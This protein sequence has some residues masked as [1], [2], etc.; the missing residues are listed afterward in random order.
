FKDCARLKEII[1][2]N[3]DTTIASN[4]VDSSCKIIASS[5]DSQFKNVDNYLFYPT[6]D[7]SAPYTLVDYVGNA[8][9]LTLPENC[10]SQAYSIHN[11]ALAFDSSLKSVTFP[12]SVET[13]GT[14]VLY[15]SSNIETL[16]VASGNTKFMSQGNCIISIGNK[17]YNDRNKLV[18]GCKTSVIPT[19]GDVVDYIANYAFCGNTEITNLTIPSNITT[20]GYQAFEGCDKLIRTDG[21]IRYVDKWAIACYYSDDAVTV[22]FADDTI[23][24]ANDFCGYYASDSNYA[25]YRKIT[26]VVT[27]ADLKYISSQAF[28]NCINLTSLTL[29]DG[30]LAIGGSAFSVC[31]KLTEVVIPDSVTTLSSAAF[32]G[33]TSLEY[34]KLPAGASSVGSQLFDGCTDLNSVVIPSNI[35][36][37][38][39]GAFKNCTSLTTVYYGGDATAWNKVT[40]QSENESLTRATVVYY[41]ETSQSGCWHYGEDGKPTLWA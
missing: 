23:G 40:K 35:T 3:P 11:Y 15:R 32:M 14:H 10:D 27:N 6:G 31:K 16:A 20:V 7:T 28:Y 38:G 30:L 13:I 2:L 33:C 4:A 1:Q 24:I 29:N 39:H 9:A 34:A 21:N 19:D 18:M 25:M 41:S 8:T 5:A 22:E 17:M 37:I 26:A 36:D 12:A